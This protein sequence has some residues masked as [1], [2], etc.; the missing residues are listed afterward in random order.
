MAT[1]KASRLAAV[2]TIISNVGQAPVTALDT[3]NPLVE[4]AEQILDEITRS[5]LAE[6]WEYNTEYNYPFTPASDGTITVSARAQ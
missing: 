6:G 1:R 4:M 5:V 3:G 2:N